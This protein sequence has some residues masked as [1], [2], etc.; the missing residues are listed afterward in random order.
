MAQWDRSGELPPGWTV[1]SESEARDVWRRFKRKF[2]FRPSTNKADWPSIKERSD[3]ITYKLPAASQIDY[4]QV[5]DRMRS[6]FCRLCRS[7]GDRIYVLDWNHR[8]YWLDPQQANEDWVIHPIPAGE[9]HVYLHPDFHW[10]LFGHP[11]EWTLNLFGDVLPAELK[12]ERLEIF[13]TA[14][15]RGGSL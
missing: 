12:R 15:L 9:Y 14:P 13:R 11:W 6:L 2:D 3:S 8:N 4:Q 7:P 1:L 10:G 5:W